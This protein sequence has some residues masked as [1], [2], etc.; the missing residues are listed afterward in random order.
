MRVSWCIDSCIDRCIEK[1]C[2]DASIHLLQLALVRLAIAHFSL[3]A[4]A[5]GVLHAGQVGWILVEQ[6]A[7]TCTCRGERE[8]DEPSH[9]T[10]SFAII[11]PPS[12]GAIANGGG[13]SG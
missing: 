3:R 5:V 2:I 9:H 11:A 13:A 4:E 6:R 12:R 10:P 8:D 7:G 1:F